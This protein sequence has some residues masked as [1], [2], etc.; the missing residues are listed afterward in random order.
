MK[1]PPSFPPFALKETK[2]KSSSFAFQI[3][4]LM[5]FLKGF[6]RGFISARGTKRLLSS[7]VV[8]EHKGGKVVGSTL[9]A[10]SA[11]SKLGG[12]VSALVAGDKDDGTDAVAQTIAK[13]QG[14]TKVI[15]AKDARLANGLPETHA[16]VIVAAA[17]AGHFTHVL[18]SH[19]AYGK[20]V[21]PRA[22][23]LLDVA[24]VSDIIAVESEDTFQRPIYAGIFEL[25][26]LNYSPR[27][28]CPNFNVLQKEMQLPRSSPRTR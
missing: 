28:V 17:K 11:A 1:P 16:P 23:A 10:I 9:N 7:L 15:V 8:V 22:A 19:S 3:K 21:L 2:K 4:S 25:L 14:V 18:A 24:Q 5:S 12:P 27:V 13:T 6:A 26:I 20:N